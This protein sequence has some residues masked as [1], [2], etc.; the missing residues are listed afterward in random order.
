[1][2]NQKRLFMPRMRA[3]WY[4]HNAMRRNATYRPRRKSQNATAEPDA[5]AWNGV[6]IS[7]RTTGISLTLRRGLYRAAFAQAIFISLCA[8]SSNR[9]E[10]TRLAE[11]TTGALRL[12]GRDR[13][14]ILLELRDPPRHVSRRAM[15]LWR[16]SLLRRTVPP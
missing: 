5:V 7:T 6:A 11:L 16:D 15:P 14:V 12:A 1:M 13:D 3:S 4:T 10:G 9:Q 8:N 2:A